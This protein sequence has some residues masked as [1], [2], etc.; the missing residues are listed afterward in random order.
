VQELLD[1]MCFGGGE[2]GIHKTQLRVSASLLN[3]GK[4]PHEIVDLLLARTKFVHDRDCPREQWDWDRERNEIDK[5]I[6]RWQKRL[7]YEQQHQ[8]QQAQALPLPDEAPSKMN[9]ARYSFYNYWVQMLAPELP[10]GLLPKAFDEYAFKVAQH[11]GTD[12]A[13][14]AFSALCFAAACIPDWITLQVKATNKYWLESARTWFSPIGDVSTRKSAM[15]KQSV[16]PLK[17]IEDQ[18]HAQ[19]AKAHAEWES[20]EDKQERKATPEPRQ[21]LIRLEDVT[22]ESAQEAFRD[23]VDG[24]LLFRDELAGWFGLMEK[25]GRSGRADH[26]YWLQSFDGG[27]YTWHRI[28]RGYGRVPN[29]GISLWGG[30]QPDEIAAVIREGGNNGLVQRIVPLLLRRA[31]FDNDDEPM[32]AANDEYQRIIHAL[33][34]KTWDRMCHTLHYD[35]EAQDIQLNINDWV[36]R[37]DNNPLISRQMKGHIGKYPAIFARLCLLFHC[38]ENVDRPLPLR[39]S[40]DT[41]RRVSE[42][43]RY[44]Y[45]HAYLFYSSLNDEVNNIDVLQQFAGWIL[46]NPAQKE[47]NARTLMRHAKR[48]N[49]LDARGVKNVFDHMVYHHWLIPIEEAKKRVNS[50][51]RYLVN[52]D[53]HQDLELQKQRRELEWGVEEDKR[54]MEM[55]FSETRAKKAR[56][57]L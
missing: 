32:D 31:T 25:Y 1:G 30:I 26:G 45:Q 3:Q 48:A 23:N 27:A 40:Y 47:V 4:D 29:I 18:L 55:R 37:V 21:K 5:I 38:I 7:E 46:R 13:G 15:T 22:V 9:G 39:I 41:T 24:L 44:L 14:L 36:I 57:T 6:A 11:M 20:I 54:I 49:R 19:W 33:F 52:V 8:Q 50:L 43:M 2:N 35:P 16:R 51:D 34:H 12:P 10:R 17:S 56:A 42:L 28:G 53:L